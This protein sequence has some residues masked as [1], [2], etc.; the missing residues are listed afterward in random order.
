MSTPSIHALLG[1]TTNP[2]YS[3]GIDAKKKRFLL[4]DT[5]LNGQHVLPYATDKKLDL[6]QEATVTTIILLDGTFYTAPLHFEQIWIM[7]VLKDGFP[8]IIIL[9]RFNAEQ[10][11]KLQQY[12]TDQHPN[13]RARTLSVIRKER[14]ILFRIV[15]SYDGMAQGYSP[16]S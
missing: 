12:L 5:V 1:L 10:E 14:L 3:T 7:R 4:S 15:E 11:A 2:N 9:Q 8:F 16:T 6:M 13:R